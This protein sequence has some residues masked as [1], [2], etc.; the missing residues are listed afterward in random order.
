MQH[1]LGTE[2]SDHRRHVLPCDRLC[3]CVCVI[4]CSSI[5]VGSMEMCLC[6]GIKHNV[7]G[8]VNGSYMGASLPVRV[9]AC[10]Y[11]CSCFCVSDTRDNRDTDPF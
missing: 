11:V 7:Y 4:V 9:H 1:P 10:V 8:Y 5:H 3:M 6:M 2:P